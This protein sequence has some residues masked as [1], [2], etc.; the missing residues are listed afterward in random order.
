MADQINI[1]AVP[2]EEPVAVAGHTKSNALEFTIPT[3]VFQTIPPALEP[4]RTVFLRFIALSRDNQPSVHEA[5]EFAIGVLGQEPSLVTS[6]S[7][8]VVIRD[9]DGN[10]VGSASCVPLDDDIFLITISKL[11]NVDG[12]S[13]EIRNHDSQ[14]LSFQGFRSSSAKATLQPRMKLAETEITLGSSDV[15]EIE[16]RNLGTS[17]LSFTD[18]VGR[19][20]PGASDVILD[21]RPE[22][23]KPHGVGKL[24]FRCGR[25]TPSLNVQ[26]STVVIGCNDQDREHRKLELELHPPPPPPPPPE[27]MPCRRCDCRDFKGPGGPGHNCKREGCGHSWFLHFDPQDAPIPTFP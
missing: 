2:A 13:I 8:D 18:L 6:T 11:V 10:A 23:L 9:P 16:V 7:Q 12:W 22:S 5:P 17:D 19:P 20:V 25:L 15:R 4:T 27:M 1:Q 3:D 24:T 14:L 21:S 26:K